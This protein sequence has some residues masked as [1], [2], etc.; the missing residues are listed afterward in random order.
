LL[1]VREDR[2]LARRDAAKCM[3]V[4]RVKRG[5]DQN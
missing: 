1:L 3:P 2:V 5:E 4:A